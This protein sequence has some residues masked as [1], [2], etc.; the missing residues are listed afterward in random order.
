[1]DDQVD[2]KKQPLLDSFSLE[3]ISE[4]PSTKE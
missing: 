3:Y 1:M 2:E 4:E